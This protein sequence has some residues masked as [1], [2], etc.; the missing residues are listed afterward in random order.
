MNT[1][2][3]E[4]LSKLIDKYNPKG[5]DW[6]GTPITTN[7]PLICRH[8]VLKDENNTKLE[9]D[10]L[11]TK[12]S[13]NKLNMLEAKDTD[14]YDEWNWLFYA[15]NFSE[16][17][18]STAYHEMIEELREQTNEVIYGKGKSLSLNKIKH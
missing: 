1:K 9:N 17:H 2:E 13:N 18:P 4:L 11:L 6:M 14:L 12:S 15:I 5:Y 7:N 10:A 16:T 3:Q 8:I